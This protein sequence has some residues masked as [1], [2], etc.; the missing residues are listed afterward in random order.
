MCE[1]KYKWK[2]KGRFKGRKEWK[3][4][5]VGEG[6]GEDEGE[7]SDA[8]S[9]IEWVS[10]SPKLKGLYEEES[11]QISTVGFSSNSYALDARSQNNH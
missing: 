11:G 7:I 6:W 1:R 10:K 4:E 5:S 9:E 2:G 8:G 3:R